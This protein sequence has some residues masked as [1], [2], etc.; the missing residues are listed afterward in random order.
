VTDIAGD[1]HISTLLL[2][3]FL[4]ADRDIPMAAA[5]RLASVLRLKLTVD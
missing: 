3:R 1:A 2:D 5:D 4:S